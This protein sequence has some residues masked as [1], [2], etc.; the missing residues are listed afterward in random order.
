MQEIEAAQAVAR[1]LDGLGCGR[2]TGVT[3]GAQ[4]M[5]R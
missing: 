3:G 1:A 4:P 5:R 2:W